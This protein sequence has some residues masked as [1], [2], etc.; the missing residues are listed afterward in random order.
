MLA[1][2]RMTFAARRAVSLLGLDMRAAVAV[3]ASWEAMAA[4]SLAR[5]S[6]MAVRRSMNAATSGRSAQ[7]TRSTS[8][9][10]LVFAMS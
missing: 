10:S 5:F 3:M 1:I 6:A 4:K 9:I 7:L 8:A 2:L